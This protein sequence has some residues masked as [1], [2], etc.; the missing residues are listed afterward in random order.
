MMTYYKEVVKLMK[1]YYGS[2]VSCDELS[3]QVAAIPAFK[4][5][6]DVT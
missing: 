6:Q 1:T 4:L 3:Q 5:V 2:L